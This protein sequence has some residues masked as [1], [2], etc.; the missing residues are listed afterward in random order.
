MKY[1]KNYQS[2][3]QR[4]EVNKCCWKNGADRLAQCR[5]ATNLQ[6]LKNT[7]SAKCSKQKHNKTRSAC[8]FSGKRRLSGFLVLFLIPFLFELWGF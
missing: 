3:T 7:V 6:F 2:V 8:N 1:R 5:V 4:Q